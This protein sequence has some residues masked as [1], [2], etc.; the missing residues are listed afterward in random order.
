M[1]EQEREDLL[2]LKLLM[3]E[4]K[5]SLNKI[6]ESQ[7]VLTKL[8]IEVDDSK[9][10]RQDFGSIVER[11]IDQ[12]LNSIEFERALNEQIK[13]QAKEYLNQEEVRDDFTKK[14]DSRFKIMFKEIQLG[15]YL[16]LTAIVGSI[17]TALAVI[18]LK[19]M[20]GK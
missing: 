9:K 20:L 14:V 2:T 12:R 10:F 13:K 4:I 7:E 17:A 3:P 15:M 19:G 16:R 11:I 1:T 18:V 5:T 8:K 6:L